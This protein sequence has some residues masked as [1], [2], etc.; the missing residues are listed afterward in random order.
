M[1]EQIDQYEANSWNGSC[2]GMSAS[3]ISFFNQNLSPVKWDSNDNAKN[4]YG[5]ATPVTDDKVNDLINFYQLMALLPDNVEMP[6]VSSNL[7]AFEDLVTYT[8]NI[9]SG[10]PLVQFTFELK[11]NKDSKDYM[12]TVVAYGITE[13]ST[14]YDI[15]IAD[16]DKE[17]AFFS[18]SK[19]FTTPKIVANPGETVPYSFISAISVINDPKEIS[20]IN[21]QTGASYVKKHDY[22][23][24]WLI[25]LKDLGS[26][27][28]SNLSGQ[29][30]TIVNGAVSGNLPIGNV[31]QIS[32]GSDEG[33]EPFETF[34]ELPKEDAYNINL[35]NPADINLS[36]CYVDTLEGVKSS[37]AQSVS[38]S[39]T[40]GIGLASEA[41]KPFELSMTFNNSTS[42]VPWSTVTVAG[43]AAATTS[44]EKTSEGIVVKGDGLSG[45]KVTGQLNGNQTT[46]NIPPSEDKFLIKETAPGK[47]DMGIYLDSNNDGTYEK[48]AQ[49]GNA[50]QT[51]SNTFAPSMLLVAV[52]LVVVAVLLM[53][54][55]LLFLRK[56]RKHTPKFAVVN[57]YSPSAPVKHEYPKTNDEVRSAAPS[58]FKKADFSNE[59]D[60]KSTMKTTEKPIDSKEKLKKK[61]GNKYYSKPD[62][63]D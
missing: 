30:D 40:D 43:N 50:I 62:D 24:P 44:M 42:T 34:Y 36:I 14:H 22:T 49:T 16:P 3:L 4:V 5:L 7:E 33:N 19:D 60:A 47:T 59:D 15:L 31:K 17:I 39:P 52:A 1:K 25:I 23:A 58:A 28:L 12:H 57:D 41:G 48:L 45:L 55:M 26:L 35:D 10:G 32:G 53:L 20:L 38:F 21:P 54:L 2:L 51:S 56:K 8:K 6:K 11:A 13:F 18:V 9:A 63:L 61:E 46:V 37:A 27:I 29:S